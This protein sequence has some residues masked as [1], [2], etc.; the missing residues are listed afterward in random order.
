MRITVIS[1]LSAALVSTSCVSPPKQE[2]RI[3]GIAPGL[4]AGQVRWHSSLAFEGQTTGDYEVRVATC[5][6]TPVFFIQVKGGYARAAMNYK[7]YGEGVTHLLYAVDA[8]PAGA[9]AWVESQSW[10][11]TKI[12]D[13]ELLLSWSRSV[14]NVLLKPQDPERAFGQV[15]IGKVRKV[16]AMCDDFKF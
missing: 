16:A 4:W 9:P 14:N 3:A 10:A 1:L 5:S 11:V 8:Q 13:D 7:S 15:G 12:A 6:G 2:L